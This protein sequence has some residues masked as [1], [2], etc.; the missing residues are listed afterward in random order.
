MRLTPLPAEQWD[1]EVQLALK[2]MVPRDRQNPE[3]AGTALS[4]LVRHPDLAKAYLGFNV[5]LLFRSTLPARLREVAVLRVAYRRDCTYE[6]A[7]H[8]EM[9]KA[10]GLTDDDV[11]AIRSGGA[12]DELD[13]LVVEAT[14]ELEEKS[15]LTDETWAALGNHLTERQRMD[16]VFTVGAYGMLAMAFNTFGVQLEN[17]R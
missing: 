12:I 11:E 1:D 16:F 5:Y 13:R 8:V 4:T 6:W 17:E 10:E 14:D 15:N 2:G 9:A 3:G 7:H